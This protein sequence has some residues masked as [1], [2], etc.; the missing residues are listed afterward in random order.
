[1]HNIDISLLYTPWY[2]LD[3]AL[4]VVWKYHVRLILDLQYDISDIDF[5]FCL[6][7]LFNSNT[8]QSTQ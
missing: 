1:M 4:C 3:F 6:E 5:L 2:F 7:V 8:N